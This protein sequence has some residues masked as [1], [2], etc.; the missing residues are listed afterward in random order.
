[1]CVFRVCE[2]VVV[3]VGGYAW[4]SPDARSEEIVYRQFETCGL[5]SSAPTTVIHGA[6]G[7]V[8]TS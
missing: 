1:M 3:V 4:C 5:G 7:T 8:G 6:K 2:V